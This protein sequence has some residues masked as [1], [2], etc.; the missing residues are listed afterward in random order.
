MTNQPMPP[1]RRP[2]TLAQARLGVHQSRR[3]L[4]DTLRALDEFADAVTVVGAHAVHVRS[5]VGFGV[6]LWV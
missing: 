3:L 5:Y 1:T 2:N 6:G 4:I